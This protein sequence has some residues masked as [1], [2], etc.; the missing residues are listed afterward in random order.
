MQMLQLLLRTGTAALLLTGSTLAQSPVTD[1]VRQQPKPPAVWPV[2]PSTDLPTTQTLGEHA[3]VATVPTPADRQGRM[4][5]Q[6]PGKRDTLRTRL[7]H[8]L[9][10][11]R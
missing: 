5:R 10:E 8:R 7:H 2:S 6:R 1:P 9:S 11:P 4:Q 3:A